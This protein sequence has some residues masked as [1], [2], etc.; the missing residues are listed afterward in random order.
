M[1]C[2]D[3][4]DDEDEIDDD[5]DDTDDVMALMIHLISPLGSHSQVRLVKM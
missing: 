2:D 3:D 5:D 1:C 4:D